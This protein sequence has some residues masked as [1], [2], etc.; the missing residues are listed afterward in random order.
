MRASKVRALKAEFI[1]ATGRAPTDFVVRQL[2]AGKTVQEA[3]AAI[4]NQGRTRYYGETDGD[5]LRRAY[6]SR[7]GGAGCNL[8]V[9][10][11]SDILTVEA[12][13][14]RGEVDALNAGMM[15][16]EIESVDAKTYRQR[17]LSEEAKAAAEKS[18]LS[19]EPLIVHASS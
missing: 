5:A 16:L 8:S 1:R 10:Q 19:R 13:V 4:S 9:A 11:V 14:E 15:I 7:G 3:I 17:F 18:P 2:K 6:F 12:K